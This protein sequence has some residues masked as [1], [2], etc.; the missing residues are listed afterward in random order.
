MAVRATLDGH[1]VDHDRVGALALLNLGHFTT[2]RVEGGGVRGLTLHLER[3][4]GDCARVF[5]AE[6]DPDRVRSHLVGALDRV[7]RP[8][9]ARVTVFDPGL[10]V[11]ALAADARP[12]VL[13]TLRPAAAPANP[14]VCLRTAV[15]QR[16]LPSV[17][18]TG[19][20]AAMWLR[21]AAQRAGA[22]DVLFVDDRGRVG[23]TSTANIGF[24]EGDLVIWPRAEWLTG[25]TMRLIDRVHP[26]VTRPLAV[27]DLGSLDG[28]FV[29]NAGFGVR[30]VTAVDDHGWPAVPNAVERVREAYESIR[31]EPL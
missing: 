29:C 11:G 31:P 26:T 7:P 5:D 27:T 14:G 23:E 17:K 22:D 9:A 15:H 28:A 19:L 13:V 8:V 6:L 21:R 18:H 30:P 2:M 25:V 16:E 1:P 24:V 4:V 12:S 3:L 10:E 20:F